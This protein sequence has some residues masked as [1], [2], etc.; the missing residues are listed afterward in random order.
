VAL[1][2]LDQGLLELGATARKGGADGQG[3]DKRHL[4]FDNGIDFGHGVSWN[5][6]RVFR[7]RLPGCSECA[8]SGAEKG[9][10]QMRQSFRESMRGLGQLETFLRCHT[11][12]PP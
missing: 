5:W 8:Y 12:Q 9:P 4:H 11:P 1:D 3:H 2:L 6:L 7:K 10:T